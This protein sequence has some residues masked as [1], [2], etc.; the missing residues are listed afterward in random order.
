MTDEAASR[1]Q[2]S[3]MVAGGCALVVFAILINLGVW[4]LRR[5]AW[6]EDLIAN[7]NERLA[8]SPMVLPAPAVWPR[9]SAEALEYRHVTFAATFL[10][11]KEARVYAAPSTFRPDVS[12][13][14]YWIFTPA[15][16]EGGIVMVNRGFVP[17]GRQDPKTRAA[18]QVAGPLNI[19]G[20]LRWPEV[21]GLFTPM[22]D[23]THNLWFARN[24]TAI[25]AAKGLGAV[26]PFYVEQ[27][28]PAPPGGL[29]KPGPLQV[30]LPNNHLQYAVTW[31]G[32]ALALVGV[33]TV[34]AAR[35][36]REPGPQGEQ[37]E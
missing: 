19:M 25:A 27:E 17:E 15:R 5:L 2:R 30:V 14:G 35:R 6:K 36:L 9:L 33:F 13:P 23:P 8:A 7:L 29:P 34:W 3:L 16:V 20:T 22:D 24:P 31:F 11:A 1:A 32:L 21:R 4:Q 12:G 28:Q 18:G 10:H 26:A 37:A